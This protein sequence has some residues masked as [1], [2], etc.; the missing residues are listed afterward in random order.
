MSARKQYLTMIENM[1]TT[2]W[3]TSELVRWM[4]DPNRKEAIFAFTEGPARQVAYA[5]EAALKMERETTAVLPPLTLRPTEQC[6]QCGYIQTVRP[7][8]EV[9]G[10]P[11]A[12]RPVD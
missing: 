4:R 3:D 7:N 12:A 11:L 9:T 8:A 5:F 6:P 10:G 2:H 1:A